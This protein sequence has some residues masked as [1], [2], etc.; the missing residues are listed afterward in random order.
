MLPHMKCREHCKMKLNGKEHASRAFHTHLSL[1]VHVEDSVCFVHD[2]E[3]QS[4]QGE[5]LRVL[6]VVYQPTR[7]GCN[8]FDLLHHTQAKVISYLKS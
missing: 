8:T 5:A 7:C 4:S 1:K 2:Q 6:Q 3:L